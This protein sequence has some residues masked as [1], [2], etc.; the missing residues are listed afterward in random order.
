LGFLGQSWFDFKNINP[1]KSKPAKP[2]AKAKI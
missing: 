2:K 1:Q